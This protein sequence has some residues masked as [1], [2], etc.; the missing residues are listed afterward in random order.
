MRWN[1]WTRR[2][3]DSGPKIGGN[4]PDGEIKFENPPERS[5]RTDI[6]WILGYR[7]VHGDSIGIK[8]LFLHR[9]ACR[10]MDYN[11]SILDKSCFWI[12]C[13]MFG[14]NWTSEIDRK[15]LVC[16]SSS[17]SVLF[18]QGR[19]RKTFDKQV[20]SSIGATQTLPNSR[21]LMKSRNH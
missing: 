11:A 7:P 1:N 17:S 20:P 10:E 8:T 12:T 19:T 14:D 3:N 16:I 15:T 4:V 18:R 6:W 9:K 5:E 21:R 13:Q 2:F